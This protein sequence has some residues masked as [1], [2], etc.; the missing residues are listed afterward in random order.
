MLVKLSIE[1]FT[2][3]SKPNLDEII[4]NSLVIHAVSMPSYNFLIGP[5]GII[6]LSWVIGKLLTKVFNDMDDWKLERRNSV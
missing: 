5:F 4:H 1:T 6:F 2:R 3:D